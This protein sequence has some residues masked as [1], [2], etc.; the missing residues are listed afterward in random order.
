MKEKE[1]IST[2]EYVEDDP[3][4]YLRRSAWLNMIYN[5][6]QLAKHNIELS[7]ERD[8]WKKKF[9][10][11]PK[12]SKKE[13]KQLLYVIDFLTYVIDFLTY[14]NKTVF[15]NPLTKKSLTKIRNKFEKILKK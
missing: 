6:N 14:E 12:F 13:I 11:Y 3:T 5:R 4:V 7:R 1:T 8:L 10:D 15:E 2:D 9:I